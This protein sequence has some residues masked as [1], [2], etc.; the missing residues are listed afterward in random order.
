[1]PRSPLRLGVTE[2]RRRPGTQRPVALAAALPDLAIT[3]A[4]VPDGAELELEGV[5]EAV[6]GSGAITLAGHVAVPWVAECRRCLEEVSGV[7]DVELREVFETRPT[8]GETYPIEGDEID[9]EPVLREAALLHLPLAPLC[10]EDCRGPAPEAFPAVREGD[11]APA[12]PD[13]EP[14]RDPRWAAL[15]VLRGEDP[16]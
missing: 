2:L 9:L 7:E 11:A 1:V 14:P 15:D 3:T 4:R 5:L 10:R 8:P 16:R 6:E 13:G 12:E